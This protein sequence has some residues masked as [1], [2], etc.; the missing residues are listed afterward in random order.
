MENTNGQTRHAFITENTTEDCLIYTDEFRCY[1]GLPRDHQ[2]VNHGKF[3]YAREEVHTNG[4]EGH[5]VL[6]K[7]GYHRTDHWMSRKH[8]NRYVQEFTTRHHIKALFPMNK[9]TYVASNMT[10]KQLLYRDL[11]A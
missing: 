4:I 10:K 7:R 3:E 1:W 11:V 6:F 8:L 9:M 2:A 5:W